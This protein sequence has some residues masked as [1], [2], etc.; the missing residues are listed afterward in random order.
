MSFERAMKKIPHVSKRTVWDDVTAEMEDLRRETE[1]QRSDL[2]ALEHARL[3][4]DA[5]IG[6]I[7]GGVLLA[8][9]W[10]DTPVAE[11]L[12]GSKALGHVHT[13]SRRRVAR[14]PHSAYTTA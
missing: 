4:Q 3:D 9:L 1:V 8:T 2:M 5:G 11:R 14:R 7:A 6:L 12:T 13:A 10:A